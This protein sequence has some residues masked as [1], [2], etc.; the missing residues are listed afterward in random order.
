VRGQ[1]AQGRQAYFV[2]PL[3]EESEAVDLKAATVHFHHLQ[4]KV[5]PDLRLGLIHGRLPSEERDAVMEQFTRRAIDILVATTVIEVGIDVANASVMVIENA[6]RFGLAQ[7]HQLR[8]RVGRGSAQS[9]C[10]LVAKKYLIRGAR[11]SS[12]SQGA[13]SIDGQRLAEQRLAAITASTD[14]FKIAEIDLELRGPGDFFGTRQSG[15][16]EFRVANIVSDATLL[17]DARSDAFAI[18]E[19]DPHLERDDHRALLGYLRAR[20]RDELNLLDVG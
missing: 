13:L 18:A 4:T 17:N 2:Y 16:P 5:F 11:A 15:M 19:S 3:I 12:R 9:F 6:E 1:I 10:I 14:G 20:Y 7:L 8:G